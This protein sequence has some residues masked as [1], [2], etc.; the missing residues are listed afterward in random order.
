MDEG[1]FRFEKRIIRYD[2]GLRRYEYVTQLAQSG[3]QSLFLCYMMEV[4]S[5]M[6]RGQSMLYLSKSKSYL[7]PH[8]A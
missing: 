4:T 3:Y 5:R 6:I 1:N 7:S 2:H 8:R